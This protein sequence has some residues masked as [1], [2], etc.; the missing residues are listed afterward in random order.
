MAAVLLTL[1]GLC[2][3]T[4]AELVVEDSFLDL[5]CEG[6][7]SP[8][9]VQLRND[10]N[11]PFE[12]PVT[13]ARVPTSR[14][15]AVPPPVVREVY[16]SPGETRWVTFTP[17][18]G[19][20]SPD[21]C[22]RWSDG[23]VAL[24]TVKARSKRVVFVGGEYSRANLPVVRD[25]FLPTRATALDGVRVIAVSEDATLQPEQEDALRDWVFAGGTLVR[26]A[27]SD[28]RGGTLA[29]SDR[30]EAASAFGR[31]LVLRSGED[32]ASLTRESIKRAVRLSGRVDTV[33]LAIEEAGRLG[34]DRPLV[35]N[36]DAEMMSAVASAMRPRGLTYGLPLILAAYVAG[37]WLVGRRARRKQWPGWLAASV[38]GLLSAA[39]VWAAEATSPL[40]GDAGTALGT[41]AVA[42]VVRPGDDETPPVCGVR[43]WAVF[44]D[45]DGG[46]RTI[47][48][49]AEGGLVSL[50]NAATDARVADGPTQTLAVTVPPRSNVAVR[51]R[52]LRP[53]EPPDVTIDSF[54]SLNKLLLTGSVRDG[55]LR[56]RGGLAQ[57]RNQ[58]VRLTPYL[59]ATGGAVSLTRH[60]GNPSLRWQGFWFRPYGQAV[61]KER[62]TDAA[63]RALLLSYAPAGRIEPFEMTLPPGTLRLVLIE[64]LPP[65]AD[66]LRDIPGEDRIVAWVVD[67]KVSPRRAD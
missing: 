59:R 14:Y 6:A 10:G 56:F 4:S 37:V 61:V 19:G 54:R 47:R 22:V 62:L 39:G 7:F 66:L 1:L 16:L 65:E 60:L 34:R 67:L 41:V 25:R 64:E 9:L 50:S 49:D 23:D 46:V 29:F 17:F 52:G 44:R 5:A 33:D 53:V 51:M 42:E 15:E 32:P 48:P 2:S 30:P 20:P 40:A 38:T 3:Q 13:L 63:G 58:V 21:Y 18:V 55:R 31:G 28:N 8:V 35:F 26:G 11:E 45:R 57:Y 36:A 12:G 24:P 27:S 43:Q